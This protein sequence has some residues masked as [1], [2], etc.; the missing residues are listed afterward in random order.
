M[1]GSRTGIVVACIAVA[2]VAG[3]IGGGYWYTH[4]QP[5]PPGG[6]SPEEP[7]TAAPPKV[8]WQKVY[9]KARGDDGTLGAGFAGSGHVTAGAIGPRGT[10]LLGSEDEGV[11]YC[12]AQAEAGAARTASWK[13]LGTADGLAE[14][15]VYALATDHRGRVWIGHGKSGV[16]VWN[17]NECKHYGIG[18]GPL[19]ER[20]FSIAV[21]PDGSVWLATSAGL[22][23][24]DDRNGTWRHYTTAHG[25]PGLQAAKLAFGP[26]GKLY[27]ALQAAGLAIAGSEDDYAHFH[28][29]EVLAPAAVE[30]RTGAGL[31]SNL[32][33]DVAVTREG[34]VYVATC[35]GLARSLDEGQTF[36]YFRGFGGAAERPYGGDT[37]APAGNTTGTPTAPCIG[38]G[39]LAEDFVSTVATDVEGRVYVGYREKAGEIFDPAGKDPKEQP[40]AAGTLDCSEPT[41]MVMAPG[42]Y[43]LVTQAKGGA[44]LL[45]SGNANVQ[46]VWATPAELPKA[47]A[48]PS[49]E[50]LTALLRE[51][52]SVR[53]DDQ[54]GPLAVALEDDWSTQGAFLGRHGKFLAALAAMVSPQDLHWGIG[55]D[56]AQYTVWSPE[57]GLRYYIH[58]N[59]TEDAG[60]LELPKPY[61]DTRVQ[62]KLTTWKVDRREAEWNDLG[63]GLGRAKDGPHVFIGVHVPAG[64]YVLSVYLHNKDG[65]TGENSLRDYAVSVRAG[66]SLADSKDFG[67]RPELARGRVRLFWYGVY[68][69]FMVRGPADYQVQV[70]RNHSYLAIVAAAMLDEVEEKSTGYFLTREEQAAHRA[71]DEA[72]RKQFAGQKREAPPEPAT[73][74]AAAD[75]LLAELDTARAVNPRWW[76]QERRRCYEA[77]LRY[78]HTQPAP[79]A[80]RKLATCC[81]YLNLFDD[82]EKLLATAGEK[83]PRAVEKVLRWSGNSDVF[84]T[85]NYDMVRAYLTTGKVK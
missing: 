50:E 81:Y 8:D 2:A 66:K 23:R 48:A 80:Q 16:T 19:G 32:C 75:A 6:P 55:M 12:D 46:P 43:V 47:A 18:D 74:A 25:L 60:A 82:W 31:P 21:G 42:G 11:Y 26:N 71:A 67:G 17:G 15:A 63:G 38:H 33:N 77:L 85:E 35:Y 30:S 3:L 5:R 78:Y 64:L 7:V 22:T 58:A 68:K 36:T 1:E 29:V 14:D 13:L 37:P 9:A 76:G 70:D 45:D 62:R 53:A 57:N 54:P 83:P 73:V 49:R 65:H 39:K 4:R 59:H 51:A 24:Y 10:L 61:L 72:L 28:A 40:R 44:R 79:D 52:R 84:P 69:Q 27:V 56:Q 34:H 41:A 20:V